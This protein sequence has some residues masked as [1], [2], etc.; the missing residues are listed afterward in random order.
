MGNFFYRVY[1]RATRL[2]FWLFTL[3]LLILGGSVY[4]A[5]QKLHYQEDVLKLLPQEQKLVNLY[6]ASTQIA[7]ADRMLFLVSGTD[8]ATAPQ[9]LIKYARAFAD[10]LNQSGKKS[11]LHPI[12]T[13]INASLTPTD[14]QQILQ[15]LPVLL[16]TADYRQLL[17]RTKPQA[18]DSAMLGNIKLLTTP[19]AMAAKNFIRQDPLHFVPLYLEKLK[20]FQL[21]SSYQL[22]QNH[23]FTQNKNYLIFFAQPRYPASNTAENADMLKE[24]D[25]QLHQFEQA[26]PG[27][28][29]HYYGAAPVAVGNATQIKHD[30]LF[31][32]SLAL[33]LLGLFMALYYR[34]AG[35]FFILFLPAVFGGSLA[36]AILYLTKGEIS[37]ISLGIG[38]ILLGITVDYSLHLFTHYRTTGSVRTVLS[39]VAPP[40]LM[41]SL[42]TASA[43]LCLLFVRAEALHDLGLF[44]AI[45]VT[46]AALFALLVMPL[47]FKKKRPAANNT[48][49]TRFVD[50]ITA[51]PLHQKKTIHYTVVVLSVFFL[52]FA[53]KAHFEGD[54]EKMNYLTPEMQAAEKIVMEHSSFALRSVYLITKGETLDKALMQQ[55]Q[56][57]KTLQQQTNIPIGQVSAASMLLPSTATQNQRI[58][59]WNQFWTPERIEQVKKNL[60]QS[61]EKYHMKASAFNN[62]LAFLEKA[63][64]QVS[65]E[66]LS[67]IQKAISENFIHKTDSLTSVMGTLKIADSDKPELYSLFNSQNTSNTTV[68]DKSTFTNYLVKALK[69]DFST[70]VWYSM[71]VVFL[72][73]LLAYGRIELAI[74]AFLPMLLSWI[75]TLGIMGLT[76]IPF[77]IFNIIISTFIFG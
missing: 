7:A 45:S 33:V 35:I 52:L 27:C 30:I 34:R 22:V 77:T 11:G 47:F 24:V 6:Q 18:I 58:A 16:D 4:L 26:H 3:L 70:L 38:S 14:Y 62:F 64:Q 13:S 54:M 61:A 37:A 23:I 29:L 74:I 50:R 68:F 8:T 28:Q 9:E 39:D 60:K 21:D 40:L 57:L 65:M 73:L 31:T 69:D 48:F 75:W 2:K 5:T 76:G 55:E 42:T 51:Y 25:K 46:V 44:A 32:V 12:N 49:I 19:A 1:I 41:S 36:L 59:R 43:F 67:S 17:K 53:G 71:V 10:S 66:Q 56:D 63:P 20:R 72:I 15:Y